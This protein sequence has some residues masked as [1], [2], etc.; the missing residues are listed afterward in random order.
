MAPVTIL[1]I[2]ELLLEARVSGE[3]TAL[4]IAETRERVGE[5]AALAGSA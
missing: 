4:G 2:G 3:P 1:A 5:M